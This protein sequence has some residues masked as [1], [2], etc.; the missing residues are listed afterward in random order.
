MTTT[1][2]WPRF[3]ATVDVVTF[4]FENIPAEAA[5]LLAG[6]QAG[7][8]AA[9]RCS[10]S[11]RT[12]SA[13]RISCNRSASPLAITPRS[14]TLAQLDRRARGIG[15]PAVLKTARLGYD[16]KGQVDVGAGRRRSPRRGAASAAASA[17]WRALSISPARSRSSSRAARTAR[18]RSIRRS[19]TGT[20][21]TS[22]T[23]PSRPRRCRPKRRARP[24]RSPATSPRR[25][26]L[27]GVLAV[28]MFVTKDGELLVNELAPRPHN[29]G[30]WT[31]D[32]C[33]TSQFE[34]LVRAICGLPL[35]S[36]ERHSD[37]VMKNLIGDE[38]ET[39]RDALADPPAQAA[40][41]RQAEILPGP[42]DGPCH[43]LDPARSGRTDSIRP[44]FALASAPNEHSYTRGR[45]RGCP[46]L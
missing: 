25:L 30:H 9:P 21:T 36:T 41:L 35:G 27:V 20:S 29:S 7:A 2:R 44:G 46:I 18:A 37:A 22:S 6:A 10:R 4:E 19:R 11:A 38:V 5:E 15:R 3:A 26:D 13:R 39:W 33:P 28:E 45:R 43:Q 16:G 32:A 31:I 42:Q 1:R 8:A 14:Q 23:R 17:S 34:Q 40:P 24:K 12:G